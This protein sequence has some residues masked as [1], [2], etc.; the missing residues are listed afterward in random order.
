[1]KI[2]YAIQTQ[3]NGHLSRAQK[4]VPEFIKKARVDILTSGPSNNFPT[5]KT[6]IKHYKGF[7]F[8]TS[9]SGSI[10]W[11]KTIFYNNYFQFLVD[12]FNS[13]VK[14]YDLVVSDYEPISAWACILRGV[15]CVALSN[16]YVLNSKNVPKPKR[17]SRIVLSAI[18]LF[19]PSK[20]GYGYHY[21]PYN[22]SLIHI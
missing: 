6:P 15:K 9:K 20:V 2:L 17:Y 21:R 16:Q 5:Y 19:C 13:P 12:I 18:N 11:I 1:M 7:K 14:N 22:L 4:L 3:G 10:N 8:F